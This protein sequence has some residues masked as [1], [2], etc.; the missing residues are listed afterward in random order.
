MIIIR[1]QLQECQKQAQFVNEYAGGKFCLPQ[2]VK[3]KFAQC[4]L[5]IHPIILEKGPWLESSALIYE[6]LNQVLKPIFSSR[7]LLSVQTSKE[8][9]APTSPSTNPRWFK[10]NNSYPLNHLFCT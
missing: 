8:I 6:M 2:F 9:L 3:S 7:P 10:E 4:P 1:K 5:H